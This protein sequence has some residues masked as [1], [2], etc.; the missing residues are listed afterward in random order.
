MYQV[1]SYEV[2]EEAGPGSLLFGTVSRGR[3]FQATENPR[4]REKEQKGLQ[5]R[6]AACLNLD[7][8]GIYSRKMLMPRE[9]PGKSS[10]VTS[11][12]VTA[13]RVSQEIRPSTL[14]SQV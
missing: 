14:V 8:K 7:G 5:A 11:E 10:A 1:P 12:A 3:G 9:K 13:S 4:A 2:T 6:E